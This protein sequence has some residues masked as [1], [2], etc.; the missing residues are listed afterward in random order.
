MKNNIRLGLDLKGG[1]QLMLQVQL[2]DAFKA[3]ADTV[4]QRLQ[5]E[6]REG[7]HRL[8]DR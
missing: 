5:D 3:D 1:S 4:I 6:L 8:S 7:V 2:Q